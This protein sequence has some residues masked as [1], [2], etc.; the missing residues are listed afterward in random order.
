MDIQTSPQA[1]CG[2]QLHGVNFRVFGSAVDMPT[3]AALFACAA[4]RASQ[5]FKI[6][7]L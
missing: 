2:P 1:G 4:A 7:L 5:P 6:T 3:F